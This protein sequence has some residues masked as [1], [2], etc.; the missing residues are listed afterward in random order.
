LGIINQQ[1]NPK[2][3][4]INNRHFIP[5]K[6][7]PNIKLYIILLVIMYMSTNK[8]E[9]LITLTKSTESRAAMAIISAHDTTPLHAFSIELLILSTTSNPLT[10]FKLGRANFS[11][12]LKSNSIDASQPYAGRAQN[13]ILIIYDTNE[14]MK[15]ASQS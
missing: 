15:H 10:E 4:L 13:F 14:A 12:S 8:R 11:P 5:L 7:L 2:K 1:Y 3:K 6:L 9:D